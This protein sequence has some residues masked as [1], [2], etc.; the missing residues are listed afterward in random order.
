MSGKDAENL[1]EEIRTEASVRRL[2]V[3]VAADIYLSLPQRKII[4]F[5]MDAFYAAIE[6]RDHD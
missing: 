4:H 1:D 2:G 6:I 5:D 3:L